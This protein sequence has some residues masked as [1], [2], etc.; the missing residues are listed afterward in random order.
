MFG[1]Q[2]LDARF[3]RILVEFLAVLI[4]VN[5]SLSAQ[6]TLRHTVDVGKTLAL[7][8]QRYGTTEARI[9]ELNPDSIAYEFG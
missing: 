9:I 7:I 4:M 1:M 3:R 5:V 2:C 6:P 8:A